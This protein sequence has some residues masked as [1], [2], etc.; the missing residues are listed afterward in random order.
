[1]LKGVL[2]HAV[3]WLGLVTGGLGVFSE[4]LRFVLP[5]LYWAYG[6]LLWAWFIVVGLSL[7]L[8]RPTVGNRSGCAL[9]SRPAQPPYKRVAPNLL[10]R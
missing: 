6:V 5:E 2:P 7:M 10:I 4:A 3:A 1:M 8:L 9:G